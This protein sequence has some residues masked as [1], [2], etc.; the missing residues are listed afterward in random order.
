MHVVEGAV[1]RHTGVPSVCSPPGTLAMKAAYEAAPHDGFHVDATWPSA[2][3][4]TSPLG[5]AGTRA[6]GRPPETART[7]PL[8]PSVIKSVPPAVTATA[9]GPSSSARPDGPPSPE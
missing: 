6:T 7:R 8:A 4:A 5:G 3:V 1:A 2:A 9:F